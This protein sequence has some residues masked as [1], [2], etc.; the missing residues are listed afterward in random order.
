MTDHSVIDNIEVLFDAWPLDCS[1]KTRY[2]MVEG[3]VT[4]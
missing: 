3:V 1:L 2:G 4:L